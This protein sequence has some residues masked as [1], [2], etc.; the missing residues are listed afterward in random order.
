MDLGHELRV[1]LYPS[2]DVSG[3]GAGGSLLRLHATYRHDLKIYTSDEGRVIL[4]AAAFAKGLLDLDGALPPIA[5]MML[6][7]DEA[8]TQMLDIMPEDG[9]MQMDSVKAELS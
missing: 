5:S 7:S 9:R 2:R 8:A 3:A 4:S 6:Q 1:K